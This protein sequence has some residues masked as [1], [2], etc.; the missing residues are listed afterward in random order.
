MKSNILLLS[1]VC[2]AANVSFGNDSAAP[3][4][5]NPCEPQ[6][7]NEVLKIKD[8]RTEKLTAKCVNSCR[9]NNVKDVITNH[10]C[11]KKVTADFIAAERLAVNGD[12]CFNDLNTTN[13]CVS[14]YSN[15]GQICQPYRVTANLLADIPYTL[16]TLIPLTN[17]VDDPNGD[18]ASLAPFTYIIPATGYYII[19]VQIDQRDLIA[20]PNILGN[21]TGYIDVLVNAG[22]FHTSSFPYLTFSNEQRAVLS[23]LYLLNAGDVVQMTYRITYVDPILGLQDV[24][25]TVSLLSGPNNCSFSAHFLSSLECGAPCQPCHASAVDVTCPTPCG[26]CE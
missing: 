1:L 5:A 19:S 20:A 10:L 14:G 17:V 12:V 7:H 6:C 13:L 4:K 3:V 26:T 16:G 9:I 8:I 25:G 22:A 23:S 18:I 24:P 11:A 2:L 21:P 15:L